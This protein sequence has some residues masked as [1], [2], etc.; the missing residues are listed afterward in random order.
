MLGILLLLPVN[1][2]RKGELG[3]RKRPA[4]YQEG[5]GGAINVRECEEA[6]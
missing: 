6:V 4:C 2:E 3:E 5:I 1:P